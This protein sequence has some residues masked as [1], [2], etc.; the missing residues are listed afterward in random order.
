MVCIFIHQSWK[1]NYAFWASVIRRLSALNF[2]VLHPDR[3]KINNTSKETSSNN[4]G[5]QVY[6]DT[7]NTLL[8]EV[9]AKVQKNNNP[10]S[11]RDD[12]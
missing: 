9:I 7:H 2:H 12:S 8:E 1:L 6:L 11:G 4:G 10:F 3:T 5:I